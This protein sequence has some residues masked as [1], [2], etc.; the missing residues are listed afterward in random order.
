MD[1]TFKRSEFHYKGGKL[2]KVTVSNKLYFESESLLLNETVSSIGHDKLHN[3]IYAVKS[4][5]LYSSN[6][7]DDFI[8]RESLNTHR[9]KLTIEKRN[10]NIQLRRIADELGQLFML[11]TEDNNS[12]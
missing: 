2:H 5:D 11:A 8:I 1:K 7:P 9:R 4:L 6:A 10:V 12:V 3:P